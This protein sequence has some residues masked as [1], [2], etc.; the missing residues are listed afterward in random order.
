MSEWQDAPE[1]LTDLVRGTWGAAE[2]QAWEN[3]WRP[4][5]A[6]YGVTP[7]DLRPVGDPGKPVAIDA[8]PPGGS[9]CHGRVEWEADGEQAAVLYAL[10]RLVEDLSE[11]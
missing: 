4:E 10:R 8:R 1:W 7:E 2:W 3:V 5:L 9:W 11:G 6:K